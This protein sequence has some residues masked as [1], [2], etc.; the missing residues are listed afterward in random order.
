M[1]KDKMF[2]SKICAGAESKRLYIKNNPELVKEQKA[3]SRLK[4]SK[5][6]MK[7]FLSN[8]PQE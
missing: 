3:K 4:K 8:E 2:C 7:K 5:L 1:R 6:S